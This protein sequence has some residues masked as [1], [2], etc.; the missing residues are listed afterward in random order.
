LQLEME[1]K[2]NPQSLLRKRAFFTW[3][4]EITK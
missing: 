3:L 4:V 1:N 2:H